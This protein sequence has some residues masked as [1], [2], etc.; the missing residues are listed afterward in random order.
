[1]ADRQAALDAYVARVESIRRQA[2][3]LLDASADHFGTTPDDVTWA[4]A[5]SLGHA[6]ER[7]KEVLVFLNIEVGE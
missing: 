3:A 4:H 1:M 5:G 6:D 7:L 2:Q